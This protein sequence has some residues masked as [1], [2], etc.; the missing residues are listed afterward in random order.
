MPI[1]LLKYFYD[2][3]MLPL[4]MQLFSS[5]V[6]SADLSLIMHLFLFAIFSGEFTT[7]NKHPQHG[8]F[9]MVLISHVSQLRHCGLCL[10]KGHNMT[11]LRIEPALPYH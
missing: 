11:K 5:T 9:C 10:A 8:Y 2:V 4:L 7:M 6:E 1:G 3:S